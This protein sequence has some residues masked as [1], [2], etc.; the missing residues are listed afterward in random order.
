MKLSGLAATG[1]PSGSRRV[2]VGK[3]AAVMEA[4][5]GATDH[6]LSEARLSRCYIASRKQDKGSDGRERG[7]IRA[8]N[9]EKH[10]QFYHQVTKKNTAGLM[11]DYFNRCE[12][13]MINGWFCAET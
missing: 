9:I 4:S 12:S 8:Y 3:E 7:R 13:I 5:K 11:F 1:V 6:A 2:L 10:D